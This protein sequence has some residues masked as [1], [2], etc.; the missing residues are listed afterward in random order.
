MGHRRGGTNTNIP[1]GLQQSPCGDGSLGHTGQNMAMV[2]RPP[3]TGKRWHC[4]QMAGAAGKGTQSLLEPADQ[5]DGHT[6]CSLQDA[7]FYQL[8][9]FSI[10]SLCEGLY[11]GTSPSGWESISPAHSLP[12]SAPPT[13]SDGMGPP[14]RQRNC[15]WPPLAG[16]QQVLRS[17]ALRYCQGLREAQTLLEFASCPFGQQPC[18]PGLAEIFIT[19]SLCEVST[20]LKLRKV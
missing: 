2:Q 3:G 19:T 4:R 17:S 15:N 18:F 16:Q 6:I 1:W 12:T 10:P 14:A 9:L 8:M 20:L 7:A 5:S 13:R 11:T